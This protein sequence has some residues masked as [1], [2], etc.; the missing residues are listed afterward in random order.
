MDLSAAVTGGESNKIHVKKQLQ[1]ALLNQFANGP[2]RVVVGTVAI[3]L[4]RK[5][6]KSSRWRLQIVSAD[7]LE[8]EA[9]A[10]AAIVAQFN[11][12][13]T[14]RIDDPK[15]P[16]DP[17]LRRMT[18]YAQTAL[19]ARDPI[20][21]IYNAAQHDLIPYTSV[22]PN[23]SNLAMLKIG[24]PFVLMRFRLVDIWTIQLL[25][26]MKSID[27][28]YGNVMIRDFQTDFFNI[29]AHYDKIVGER[30]VPAAVAKLFP[31][32]YIG[33][34]EEY[35]Q[36]IKKDAHKSRSEKMVYPYMPVFHKK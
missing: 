2:G 14:W 35:S 25:M 18:F 9:Q 34:L 4:I 28:Q 26:Q 10:V 12:S 20:L 6:P 19:G 1:I 29:A 23:D 3:N 17:R 31:Q 5:Q 11:V 21:D 13:V 7:T 16:T 24:S 36:A 27:A 8:S 33:R 32:F 15:I 22:R 30:S